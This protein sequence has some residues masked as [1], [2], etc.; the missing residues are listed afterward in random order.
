LTSFRQFL[1][2][3]LLLIVLRPS[4]GAGQE[5]PQPTADDLTVLKVCETAVQLGRQ[6]PD[7]IWPG[8]NLDQI[9]L[10]VYIPDR[11]ALLLNAPLAVEGFVDY[12]VGWPDISTQVLYH[13]GQY[14]NLAGQLAFDVSIDSLAVCAVAFQGEE[15]RYCLEFLVHE[16][17]HQYQHK[18][19]GEIPWEREELY[20]F[21]DATN[22]SL[23]CLEVLLLRDAIEF[24]RDSG[25]DSALSR[26]RQFAAVRSHRWQEADSYVRRYEQGQEINEG[27]AK[28]VEIRAISLVPMMSPEPSDAS[29]ASILILEDD[30]VTM[31]G[32]LIEGLD[33]LIVNS[34]IAPED[35]PRNRIYPVGAAQGFLLDQLAVDWK[36]AAEQAGTDFTF[37]SL[38]KDALDFDSLQTEL[39]VAEAKKLYDYESIHQDSKKS[40]AAYRTGFDSAISSFELQPGIRIEVNFNGKNLMRSRSSKAKKWLADNGSKE[41]R[42]HFDIYVLRN[43]S[44]EDLPPALRDAGLVNLLGKEFQFQL[45]DAGLFE[46]TNWDTND[47]QL[48]FYCP[49]IQS[50]TI[51]KVVQA[52]TGKAEYRF[53]ELQINGVGFELKTARAG[54]ISISDQHISITL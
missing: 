43:L 10:I 1:V 23:A 30:S 42:D 52:F 29:L 53:E 38:L 13:S 20:P 48:V 46:A 36:P 18:S 32:C 47:K 2:C 4:S 27:T 16:N 6:F 3:V 39:L 14:E 25:P 45:K 44:P 28:Y 11:W 35:M 7:S 8:Y 5:N 34:T 49:E 12:P 50:L 17:F 33:G 24:L 22:T 40:I 31:S 15:S 21:E 41:Y 26:I 51:N 37:E 19:F 54:A 9:P